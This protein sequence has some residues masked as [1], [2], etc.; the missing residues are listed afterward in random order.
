M[1]TN[2]NRKLSN[3]LFKNTADNDIISISILICFC[4]LV[5]SYV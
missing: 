2:Q 4:E 5:L 1:E 3:L